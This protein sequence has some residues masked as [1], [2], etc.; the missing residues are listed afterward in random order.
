V[1]QCG[2]VFTLPPAIGTSFRDE[3]QR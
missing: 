3:P 1:L 2:H